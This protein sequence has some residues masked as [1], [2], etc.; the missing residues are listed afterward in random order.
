MYLS[1]LEVVFSTFLGLGKQNSLKGQK[2]L[3]NT[4]KAKNPD[5]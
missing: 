5:S 2:S 4:D 1:L 3:Q